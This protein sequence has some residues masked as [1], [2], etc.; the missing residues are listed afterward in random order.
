[1]LEQDNKKF[2]AINKRYNTADLILDVIKIKSS[3]SSYVGSTSCIG[4][5]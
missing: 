3:S 4:Q 5:I 2:A 1:M